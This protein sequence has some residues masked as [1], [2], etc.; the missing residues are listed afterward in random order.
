MKKA[1]VFEDG[2]VFCV[3]VETEQSVY[4]H[5]PMGCPWCPLLTLPQLA[6]D[7]ARGTRTVHGEK[8]GQ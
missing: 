2:A 1:V 6:P 5:T 7:A 3:D 8:A 4:C